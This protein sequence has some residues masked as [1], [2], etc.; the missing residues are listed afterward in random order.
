M[1]ATY[2]S[3]HSISALLVYNHVPVVLCICGYDDKGWHGFKVIVRVAKTIELICLFPILYAFHK[4]GTHGLCCI[5]LDY[6]VE[7]SVMLQV[8]ERATAP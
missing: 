3:K 7:V 4:R 6:D 8:S 2:K 1:R 5:A